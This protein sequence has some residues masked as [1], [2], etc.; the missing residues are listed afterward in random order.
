MSPESVGLLLFATCLVIFFVIAVAHW[1]RHSHKSHVRGGGLNDIDLAT[2]SKILEYLTNDDEN[3]LRATSRQQRDNLSLIYGQ[4]TLDE[5]FDDIG[6]LD[7]C[8]GSSIVASEDT[9][10]KT[11][12]RYTR[13]EHLKINCARFA[14]NCRYVACGDSEGSVHI[15]NRNMTR[16]IG[17]MRVEGPVISISISPD[18]SKI[19]CVTRHIRNDIHILTYNPEFEFEPD[20]NPNLEWDSGSDSGSDSP[21][22]HT[23]IVSSRQLI[24]KDAVFNPR[25]SSELIFTRGEQLMALDIDTKQERLIIKCNNAICRSCVFS[26]D[27]LRIAISCRTRKELRG[28]VAVYS[29]DILNGGSSPE[30][31]LTVP[32]QREYLD[33]IALSRNGGGLFHVSD[34][35]AIVMVTHVSSGMRIARVRFDDTVTLIRSYATN[36]V[37]IGAGDRGYGMYHFVDHGARG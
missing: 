14:P 33:M 35:G 6:V 16:H 21:L 36:Q 31:L 20:H 1:M 22:H 17:S 8:H 10:K 34:N 2:L 37:L 26:G 15:V 30:P 32:V 19:A 12:L 27:G 24:F 7:V 11:A 9:L 28:E 5:A 25:D 4:I 18:G 29:S 3:S 23:H 13:K